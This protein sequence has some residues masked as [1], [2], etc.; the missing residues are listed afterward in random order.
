[1]YYDMSTYV[2]VINKDGASVTTKVVVKQ[3]RYIPITL[4]LKRW[5]PCEETAQQMM[6]HKEEICDSEDAFLKALNNEGQKQM[7]GAWQEV[8][9]TQQEAPEEPEVE[10]T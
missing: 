2:K 4:R 7:V 5:F 3:H 6:W 1:M 9:A 10:A 8:G